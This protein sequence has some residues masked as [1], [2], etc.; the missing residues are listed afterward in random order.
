ML[1][2]VKLRADLVLVSIML[3]MLY[4]F[5]PENNYRQGCSEEKAWS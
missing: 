3:V 5:H 2:E 4:Y 1:L